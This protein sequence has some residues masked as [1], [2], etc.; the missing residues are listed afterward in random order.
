MTL[1]HSLASKPQLLDNAFTNYLTSFNEEQRLNLGLLGALPFAIENLSDQVARCYTQ[2]KQQTSHFQ[3][4]RY[5]HHIL[6]VSE[7]LFYAF[8]RQHLKEI[9]PILYTPTVGEVVQSFNQNF[10]YPRGLYLAWPHRDKLDHIL[11]QYKTAAFDIAVLTDGERILGLGDQGIGGIEICIAKALMY[12]ICGQLSPQRLLPIYLDVG[13]NN[14]E[15]LN[16]PH[17]LGWRHERIQGEQYDAFIDKVVTG[18]QK[19][20]P[21]IYL[22]WEDLERD[23]AHRLLE[24]YQTQCCTFND[25][26]QGTGIVTL[27]SALKAIDITKIPLTEQRI[28]IFGGGTAGVGIADQLCQLMEKEGLTQQEARRRI[29]MMGRYGLLLED[30]HNLNTLQKPY[31]RPT[32]E[33]KYYSA[34]TG[35]VIDLLAVIRHIKP[36][37]LIG[38]A[39]KANAFTE[40]MIREMAQHVDRPIIFPLSNPTENCEA[41]PT[42][43]LQWTQG[44][45][46]IATGSPFEDVHLEGK[47]WPISQCNNALVFPGLGLGIKASGSSRVTESMLS[48]AC[49]AL[50]DATSIESEAYPRLLPDMSEIQ[51][52]SQKIACAVVQT[53]Q[54]EGVAQHAHQDP[55]KLVHAQLWTP[56][57]VNT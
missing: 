1:H 14:P 48:A 4:N 27:A 3:K 45:A 28:I 40:D 52:I 10:I 34:Q 18:L 23:N 31:A 20:F 37:F 49:M 15:L 50:R 22:H 25:D 7:P 17:Y 6:M 55:I 24:R 47:R 11:D 43:L 2:F 8:V 30:S 54:A 12:V 9:L 16:D 53:A 46:L 29:W 51:K 44:R 32:A 56:E 57:Q 36:T 5:L 42:Q 39:G 19:R 26:M 21:H 35:E 33:R 38:C 13:T 41:T